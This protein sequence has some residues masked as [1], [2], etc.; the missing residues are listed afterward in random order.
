M[1][2]H[3]DHEIKLMSADPMLCCIRQEALVQSYVED[4]N[5]RRQFED[6]ASLKASLDELRAEISSVRA[7]LI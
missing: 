2:P 3:C 4:A 6:A 7:T 1:C 5:S